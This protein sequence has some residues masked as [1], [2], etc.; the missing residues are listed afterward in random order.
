M[1]KYF[2]INLE[3]NHTKFYDEI[4][5]LI[6]HKTSSYVCVID[7]NVLTISASNPE[8]KVILNSSNINTCDG[9]S[10]ALFASLIHKKKYLALNGP[11][12]FEELIKNGKLKHLLVGNTIEVVNK[13]RNKMVESN[14][15]ASNLVHVN[16]PFVDIDKFDYE[17]I[18]VSINSHKPDV[19][20]VSLG[21]PKQEYFMSKIKP[22]L[23]QGVMFGIG[24]AFNFYIGHITIPKRKLG[25]L[26]LIWLNRILTEPRK[27]IRR[28]LQY[29][30]VMP[31]L[32]FKEYYHTKR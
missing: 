11:T 14:L 15:D 23:N 29:V 7:S 16:L 25:S 22:L 8:Y 19:I 9:S 28:M 2:G 18:A 4:N 12:I 31:F 6:S 3:F 21:A 20:W 26:Q 30:L 32:I 24:A 5:N 17:K 1:N 10:I 27:Q 13:I